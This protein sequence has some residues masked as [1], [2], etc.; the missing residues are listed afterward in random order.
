MLSTQNPWERGFHVSHDALM[1]RGEAETANVAIL[2]L[3]FRSGLG[4]LCHVCWVD[5]DR[6]QWAITSGYLLRSGSYIE[7]SSRPCAQGEC[8]T[9]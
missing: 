7:Q 1:M 3:S 4:M 8:T 5:W 9:P 6:Y 2:K